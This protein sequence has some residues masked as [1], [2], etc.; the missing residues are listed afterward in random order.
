MKWHWWTLINA[1]ENGYAEIS[2]NGGNNH[3]RIRST[4]T[5]ID[6][7]SNNTITHYKRDKGSV[8]TEEQIRWRTRGQGRRQGSSNNSNRGQGSK[9]KKAEEWVQDMQATGVIS[10]AKVKHD[11]IPAVYGPPWR[12][13]SDLNS[14]FSLFHNLKIPSPPSI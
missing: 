9:D 6:R 13:P 4:T 1:G 8:G 3:A 5:I 2:C 10:V 7:I 12:P 14:T 11:H